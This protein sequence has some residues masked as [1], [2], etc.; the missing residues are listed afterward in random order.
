MVELL[1]CIYFFNE[2]LENCFLIAKENNTL[3]STQRMDA[4][5]SEGCSITFNLPLV[6]LEP[7]SE[8]DISLLAP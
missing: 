5:K 6:S 2:C 4:V 8:R 1:K 3:Y 7:Y